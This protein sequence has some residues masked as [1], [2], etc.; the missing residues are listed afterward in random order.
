MRRDLINIASQFAIKIVSVPLIIGLTGISARLLSEKNTYV[1]LS[2]ANYLPL[3]G[4]LQF[5]LGNVI[6]RRAAHEWARHGTLS[7]LPELRG[8][9]QALFGISVVVTFG[10]LTFYRVLPQSSLPLLVLSAAYLYTSSADS[11]RMGIGEA[12]KSNIFFVVGY[13]VSALIVGLALVFHR[14]D[15]ALLQIA[16]FG[17][18]YI[19]SLC[20]F[21]LMLKRPAFRALAKPLPGMPIAP[22]FSEAVPMFLI[23]LGSVALMNIALLGQFWPAFPT[24]SLASLSCMRICVSGINIYYFA[25]QPLAPVILRYRYAEQARF[26]GPAAIALSLVA[27]VAIVAAVVIAAVLPPFVDLWLGHR[28]H[29]GGL[30]ASQWGLAIGLWLFLATGLFFCQITSRPHFAGFSLLAG[31]STA[32]LTTAFGLKGSPETIMIAA[33]IVATGGILGAVLLAIGDV[34]RAGVQN[35]RSV[36][37][38]VS[39]R[40]IVL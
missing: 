26:V 5:G 21:A 9:F 39:E 6:L 28:A 7:A 33:L 38:E 15:P 14:P 16:C 11:V 17:S 10:L 4:I 22:P 34:A 12:Y 35:P 32:I 27:V 19:A 1:L 25:I 13:A 18:T 29:V 31:V 37:G 23:A 30:L 3:I 2:V 20:S 8:A 40:R 24:I 36:G